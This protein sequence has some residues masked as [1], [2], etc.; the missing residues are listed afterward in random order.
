MKTIEDNDEL[1]TIDDL[2]DCIE[3]LRV[4]YS[5]S[6]RWMFVPPRFQDELFLKGFAGGS[7]LASDIK[8]KLRNN[9]ITIQNDNIKEYL[10]ILDKNGHISIEVKISKNTR[11]Y[12]LFNYP[13]IQN[14]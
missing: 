9:K 3:R 14:K 12:T 13:E 2:E 5:E 8:E 7:L 4:K 6:K 11:R 1:F 10:E